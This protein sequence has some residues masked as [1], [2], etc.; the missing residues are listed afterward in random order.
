M[1][2]W[3]CPCGCD[4]QAYRS[5]CQSCRKARPGIGSVAP[6][7]PEPGAPEWRPAP[8]ASRGRGP[9]F[10]ALAGVALVA[11]L[12]V[13][14]SVKNRLGHSTPKAAAAAPAVHQT[15]AQRLDAV[16]A[17]L[18]AYVE[19]ARGLKFT[20]RPKVTILQD[21]AFNQKLR[22]GPQLDAPDISGETAT[23]RALGL[24]APDENIEAE[25]DEELNAVLGFYD[26]A[27]KELY[28]RGYGTT[29]YAKFILVHELTH[30]LQDQHFDIGRRPVGGSDAALAASSVIEGDAER[31]MR[32]YFSTL[33]GFEQDVIQREAT[34]RGDDIYAPVSYHVNFLNFPYVVG[35]NFANDVLMVGG[36]PALDG[37]FTGLPDSTEQIIH[38]DRYLDHERPLPV[39]VPAAGGPVVDQGVIG[40]FDLIAVL[41]PVLGGDTAVDVAASWGGSRYVT[42]RSGA[43]SCIRAA[44]IM[45]DPSST[46]RLA[47]A[48]QAW[49]S[50]RP[51]ATVGGTRNVVLT[52]CA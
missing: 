10:V 42:W 9:A 17:E 13:A 27:T 5:L 48:L 38:A 29:P 11:L 22:S 36:Q 14:V 16:V 35:K 20:Q 46:V 51:G 2:E 1:G 23:L 34:Q 45:D 7:P 32:G 44:F 50:T 26:P 6:A 47:L 8:T 40:E 30:A 41:A 28:V 15:D 37:A 24:L 19:S 21:A 25:T 49:A 3:R 39:P 52:A 43:R 31:V 4:N 18:S 33:T 12:V